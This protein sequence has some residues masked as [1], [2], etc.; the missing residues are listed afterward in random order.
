[1][2][3]TKAVV[4]HQLDKLAGGAGN[5]MTISCRSVWRALGESGSLETISKHKKSWLAEKHPN[6]QPPAAAPVKRQVTLYPSDIA[7]LKKLLEM[8]GSIETLLEESEA[9]RRARRE[10]S[11]R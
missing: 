7:K 6:A 11:R 3:L 10:Q 5:P 8:A 4:Y 9:Q 1:M 2:A